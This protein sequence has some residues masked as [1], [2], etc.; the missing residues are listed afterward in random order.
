M[1]REHKAPV[2]LVIAD[3]GERSRAARALSQAG[4]EIWQ[5][6][7][8]DEAVALLH[9]SASRLIV[10]IGQ[11]LTSV[12][13]FATSDRRLVHHHVYIPLEATGCMSDPALSQLFPYLTLFPVTTPTPDT[14]SRA[15][16]A[17]ARMLNG[18]PSPRGDRER[19]MLRMG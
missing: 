17:A 16:T 10:L 1:P 12:L 13:R 8:Y 5:A 3:C 6:A 7:G 9:A 11:E 2:L 15:V 19:S 14:L 4:F 18:E